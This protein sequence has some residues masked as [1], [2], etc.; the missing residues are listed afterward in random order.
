MPLMI[1][2]KGEF[3]MS[4]AMKSCLGSLGVGAVLAIL[5]GILAGNSTGSNHDN[6]VAA[7]ITCGSIAGICLIA[8]IVL[9]VLRR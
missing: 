4:A 5:F 1:E 2:Q 8:V 9:A 6:Y 7:A 3:A